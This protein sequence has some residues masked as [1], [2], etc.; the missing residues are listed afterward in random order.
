[1]TRI[2]RFAILAAVMAAGLCLTPTVSN[3]AAAQ[4]VFSAPRRARSYYDGYSPRYSPGNRYGYGRYGYGGYR[5]SGYGNGPY[6]FGAVPFG[7][8]SAGGYGFSSGTSYRLY[9]GGSLL[10]GGTYIPNTVQYYSPYGYG[11]RVY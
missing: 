6:G 10:R 2:T 3:E 7:Y 8:P 9:G 11:Y 5:Y 1:M 4:I